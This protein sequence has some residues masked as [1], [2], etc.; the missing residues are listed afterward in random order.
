MPGLC[1]AQNPRAAG[2]PPQ[3]WLLLPL[4]SVLWPCPSSSCPSSLKVKFPTELGVRQGQSG[5][6][7]M[8]TISYLQECVFAAGQK[9]SS[10]PIALLHPDCGGPQTQ[11]PPSGG[12]RMVSGIRP[13]L[14]FQITS[15]RPSASGSPSGCPRANSGKLRAP[16]RGRLSCPVTLDAAL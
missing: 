11:C 5:L 16:T 8:E 6:G 3:T 10:P 1:A 9:G 13:H 15:Q 2:R 12:R 4:F 7:G 14:I